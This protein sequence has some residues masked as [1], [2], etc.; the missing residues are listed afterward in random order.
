MKKL[1]PL[2]AE[3]LRRLRPAS[4]R[5]CD[6]A[7]AIS[8]ELCELCECDYDPDHCPVCSL[9]RMVCNMVELARKFAIKMDEHLNDGPEPR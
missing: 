3:V 1:T 8:N 6:A 4:V 7:D 5:V 2:Q 9:W